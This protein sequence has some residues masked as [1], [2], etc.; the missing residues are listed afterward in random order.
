MNPLGLPPAVAMR[1]FLQDPAK[2]G[3]LIAGPEGWRTAMMATGGNAT[4]ARGLITNK[5]VKEGTLEV[6]KG[7]LLMGKNAD[8]TP[9]ELRNP[10]LPTGMDPVFGANGEVT[11]ARVIPGVA[12]GEQAIAQAGATGKSA[13]EIHELETVGGGHKT[14]FGIPPNMQGA[15]APGGGAGGGGGGGGA[16][17]NYFAGP[18]RS[19]QGPQAAGGAP[20]VGGGDLFA[21]MPKRQSYQGSSEFG[22]DPHATIMNESEAKKE[23]ELR[24]KY[25]DESDLAD[26]RRAF[27]SIALD[28]LPNAETGPLAD[29]INAWRQKAQEMGVPEDMIPGWAK[30]A[31]SQEM[32]KALVRNAIVS[33]KPNFG[34][35]PAAA[36]FQV[37]KEEAN[38]S[39]KMT[40]LAI[41]RLLQIDNELADY[42]KQ[43]SQDFDTAMTHG[44]SALRF[45]NWYS[46]QRPVQAKLEAFLHPPSADD[47]KAEIA[48]RARAQAGQ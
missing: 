28:N 27:N 24:D 25:G 7:G 1:A 17:P 23:I 45:Q 40:A 5:L 38:P 29:S 36:E 35:R 18:A 21:S 31:P 3:E 6:R 8:G 15:P 14:V 46:H 9:F 47:V 44:G 4:A 37:L 11:G 10:D 48:R 32:K 12:Q 26:Q 19:P 2:Y 42:Q 13:G 33:L 22:S 16:P 39:D 41:K 34:G 30:V 20:G 43:R